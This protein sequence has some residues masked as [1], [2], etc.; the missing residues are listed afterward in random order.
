PYVA[1]R[2]RTDMSGHIA[3]LGDSIFDNAPYTR[4]APDVVSH[5]RNILLQNWRAYLL[6]RDGSVLADLPQQLRRVPPEASHTVVSI[7]GNDALFQSGLLN[8]PVA[9]TAEALGLFADQSALF[10]ADY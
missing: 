6:A 4:G 7:G 3:L 2:T 1:I 5:L 8:M 10:E 9:S